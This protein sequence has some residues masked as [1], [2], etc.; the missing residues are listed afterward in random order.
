MSTSSSF[1]AV[2]ESQ[3]RWYLPFALGAA[4]TALAGLAVI[5][6]WTIAVWGAA[7]V[8]AL[9]FL[10]N[11]AF[12][13]AFIFLLPLG[14]IRTYGALSDFGIAARALVAVGFFAGRLCRGSLDVKELWRPTITRTSLLFLGA[15]LVAA[16]FCTSGETRAAYRGVYFI[17]TYI[18]FYLAMFTWVDT[19]E[20]LR[21]ILLTLMVSSVFVCGFAFY[22]RIVDGYTQLWL[23]LYKSGQQFDWVQRPPSVLQSYGAL[24]AYLNLV[25][26]FAL[27]CLLLSPERKWKRIS[28]WVLVLGLTALLLTQTR[29]A[30]VTFAAVLLTAI[31]QFP[32]SLRKRILL[33]AATIALA[34]AVAWIAVLLAPKRFN[35]EGDTSI[36]GRL[37]L[38]NTA[39]QLFR[40]SPI[41]G[42]GYGTFMLI[43]DRYLPNIPGLVLGLEVHNIFF[44]LLAETG[45]L[46]F[47]AYSAFLYSVWRYGFSQKASG[48]W[49][50]RSLAFAVLASAVEV[51]IGGMTDQS[52]LWS[53]QPA[54]L[55][56]LLSALLLASKRCSAK[57]PRKLESPA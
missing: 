9:S 56:W 25:L 18:A 29:G 37:M 22:Q 23:L 10:E 24:G 38:W 13:L 34:I 57:P 32:A 36:L 19:K 45:I 40:S 47:A 26:G 2:P 6:P 48:D 49:L 44:E 14:M 21:K 31:W 35:V 3:K 15:V 1:I 28:G 17:A 8:F 4:A 16:V 55:V 51:V 20:K 54:S 11:K 12:F 41:H 7:I 30:Y 42:V 43:V 53:P 5:A 39:W 27:A 50:H 46:G 52:I 33:T